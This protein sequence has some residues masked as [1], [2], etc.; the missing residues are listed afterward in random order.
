MHSPRTYLLLA[1]FVGLRA[2]GNLS[3]ALGTKRFP[4]ALSIHPAAYLGAMLDPFAA[5]GIIMLILAIF[6]RMAIFSV[7]DL[8]FVLPVT[9]VGYVLAA[10]LGHVILYEPVS[11]ERWAGAFLI[12]AGAA[13]VGSTPKNTTVTD[14]VGQSR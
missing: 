10:L 12:F 9:A 5:A 7:A 11:G 3:L 1:L 13:L 4:E 2:F 14:R 6:A 8:S